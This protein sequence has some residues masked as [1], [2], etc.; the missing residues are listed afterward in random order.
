MS[1]CD[2]LRNIRWV[3]FFVPLF[4]ED[5]LVI[6]ALK[7]RGLY[8]YVYKQQS[9]YGEYTVHGVVE[10]YAKVCVCVCEGVCVCE[11]ERERGCVCACVLEE[12]VGVMTLIPHP[13]QASG[14]AGH[15]GEVLIIKL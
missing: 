5:C 6:F 10:L 14:K 3:Y 1:T 8:L 9:L 11:R 4:F 12:G 13:K 15:K 2:V 7:G